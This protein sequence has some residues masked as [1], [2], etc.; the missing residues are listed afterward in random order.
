MTGDNF[1][2]HFGEIARLRTLTFGEFLAEMEGA[3]P[4]LK[5]HRNTGEHQDPFQCQICSLCITDPHERL[6]YLQKA[7]ARLSDEPARKQSR[8]Y[9]NRRRVAR[10]A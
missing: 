9:T 1:K 4:Q 7:R 5:H 8:T 2:K 3:Y 6:V 10:R